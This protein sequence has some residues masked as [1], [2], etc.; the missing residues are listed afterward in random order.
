MN[1]RVQRFASKY[2]LSRDSFK[3]K[4]KNPV[5]RPKGKQKL[6]WKVKEGSSYS[7]SLSAKTKR[8]FMKRLVDRDIPPWE[9]YVPGK[10]NTPIIRNVVDVSAY[11]KNPRRLI[12]LLYKS[13]NILKTRKCNKL[14]KNQDKTC[15]GIL[16][17]AYNPDAKP[18]DWIG[19]NGGYYYECVNDG[20]KPYQCSKSRNNHRRSILFGSIIQ[21]AIK[22]ED[23]LQMIYAYAVV[24]HAVTL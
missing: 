16:H 10:E 24:S 23:L 3:V 9:L 14:H 2:Y 19:I 21:G 11:V 1:S 4:C 7:I 20:S 12:E 5:G 8:R 17:M 6:R 15:D 18:Q 13:G 22:A